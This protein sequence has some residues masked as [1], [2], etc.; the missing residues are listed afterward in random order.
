VPLGYE[1]KLWIRPYLPK[2]DVS[3]PDDSQYDW[4]R[5]E[6]AIELNTC[7]DLEVF[8]KVERKGESGKERG[9][10]KRGNIGEKYY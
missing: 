5:D 7:S 8:N 9:K 1:G 10:E 3:R 6:D 2:P 4:S